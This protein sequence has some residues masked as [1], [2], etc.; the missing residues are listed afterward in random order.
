MVSSKNSRS[1]VKSTSTGG[2]KS[3]SSMNMLM[4]LILVFVILLAI[5]WFWMRKPSSQKSGFDD[6]KPIRGYY[7]FAWQGTSMPAG[8]WDL[9][10]WFGG[11]VPKLAI[12]NNIG[13][14]KLL[15]G[16]KK[17]LNLGGG[18][19]ETGSWNLSDFDYI[20]SKLSDI[21]SAGWDGICFDVEACQPNVSFVEAFKNCFAKC[22]QTGLIVFITMSHLVPYACKTG[23]GQGTDLVNA[24]IADPNIDY[25]S[26]QLYSSGEL[27]EPSRLTQFATIRD[28]IL[29]SIPRE[30]DW[31]GL[32]A[33]TG[34][35]CP[36]YIIWL[37]TWNDTSKFNYCGKSWED[38]NTKCGKPCPKGTDSECPW[39]EKC[40]GQTG[41]TGNKG[42]ITN[43]PNFC[44]PP[45]A[46]YQT[47]I[48]CKSA[49]RCNNKDNECPAGQVCYGGIDCK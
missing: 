23:K 22:K 35:A 30:S 42:D 11:E 19:P 41:C 32:A 29:P 25:I 15:N 9:A 39:G 45:N 12:D 8:D 26:P 46:W 33:K 17:L 20:N 34:L 6:T 16:R 3:M 48:N 14:A 31:N 27:L 28:K 24:W 18:L 40:W 49:A 10:I 38:A 44:G 2:S 47:S 36:G 21:K 43:K 4:V 7:K 13:K 5:W 1:S 37:Q